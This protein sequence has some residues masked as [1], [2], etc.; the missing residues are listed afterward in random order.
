MITLVSTR[1]LNE[2]SFD[3]LRIEFTKVVI[4]NMDK[5]G[6]PKVSKWKLVR[7]RDMSEMVSESRQR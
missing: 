3:G 7:V 4:M 1:L 2:D 5:R 6:E